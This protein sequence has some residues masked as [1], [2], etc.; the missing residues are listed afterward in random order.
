MWLAIIIISRSSYSDSSDLYLFICPV[1]LAI[2]NKQRMGWMAKRGG[3]SAWPM[4][5]IPASGAQIH[6][7][8]VLASRVQASIAS[9]VLGSSVLFLWR[10]WPGWGLEKG[11]DLA[12]PVAVRD[13]ARDHRPDVAVETGAARPIRSSQRRAADAVDPPTKGARPDIRS[14]EPPLVLRLGGDEPMAGAALP[15]LAGAHFGLLHAPPA[16]VAVAPVAPVVPRAP[17]VEP[18]QLANVAAV[19]QEVAALVASPPGHAH[20]AS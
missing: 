8:L 1:Q 12:R 2:S 20:P 16:D 6:A 9:D 5:E 14:S 15:P 17:G 7:S 18:A 3:L 11:V 4:Q 10:R 19:A 13:P